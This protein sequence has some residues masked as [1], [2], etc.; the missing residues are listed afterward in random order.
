MILDKRKLIDELHKSQQMR[1]ELKRGLARFG[2][3]RNTSIRV[4]RFATILSDCAEA[5]RL[6]V[7]HDSPQTAAT[8]RRLTL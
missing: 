3:Y 8:V 7:I 2:G 4:V 1:A 6:N 5:V